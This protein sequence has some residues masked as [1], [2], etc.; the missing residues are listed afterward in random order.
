MN[1][2]KLELLEGRMLCGCKGPQA[3]AWLA[4]QGLVVPEAANRYTVADATPDALIVARLGTTEFFLEELAWRETARRVA[5]GLAARPPGVY[6]VLRE[7]WALRL[8]GAGSADFLAQVCNIDF[9]ALDPASR[10]VIMTQMVGVSVLVIPQE[11]AG[12]RLYRIWCDP[13][14]GP[15]LS[16]TL[17]GVVTD[18]DGKYLK[19]ITV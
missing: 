14:F 19:G 15:W 16:E 17:A 10:P 13:T 12:N 1:T 8:G 4:A 9:A 11:V 18:N 2:L 6:P 5:A 3:A 7:D